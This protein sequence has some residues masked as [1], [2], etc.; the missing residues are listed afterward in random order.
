[1]ILRL[2][3]LISIRHE[4]ICEFHKSLEAF[5]LDLVDLHAYLANLVERNENMGQH[6]AIL[7]VCE[8]LSSSDPCWKPM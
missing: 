1:M 4:A 7:I 5:G 2:D 8:R 3:T 6:T